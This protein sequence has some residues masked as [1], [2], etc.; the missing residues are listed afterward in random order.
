MLIGYVGKDPEIRYPEK[1]KPVA[2]ISLATNE[3]YSNPDREIT[4]WH[5]LVMAGYNA[6]FAEKYIRKG[7]HLFV[8]GKLRTREYQDRMKILRRKT[9]IIVERMELLGRRNDEQS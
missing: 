8:E 1:D 6:Q 9:E 2:Y 4:E 5:Y 3:R 7:S